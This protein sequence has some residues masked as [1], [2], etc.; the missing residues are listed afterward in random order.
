MVGDYAPYTTLQAIFLY[1]R[2][3]DLPNLA[4]VKWLALAHPQQT[5]LSNGSQ[6]VELVA[7][8]QSRRLLAA[9]R[10]LNLQLPDLLLDCELL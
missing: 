9:R 2:L 10:L 8:A 1:F 5:G 6:L 7:L 4:E 3:L